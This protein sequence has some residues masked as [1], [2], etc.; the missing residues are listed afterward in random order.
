MTRKKINRTYYTFM[1][2]KRRSAKLKR[3]VLWGNRFLIELQYKMAR[4][5][6]ELLGVE[7][8][9]DHIIPLQGALVSG[10]HVHNNLQV[11][12]ASDNFMKGNR[13]DDC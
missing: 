6:T 9:V 12:K 8:H 11:I 7:Y 13:Y 10:L 3:T 4:K 2:G 5:M 1:Q